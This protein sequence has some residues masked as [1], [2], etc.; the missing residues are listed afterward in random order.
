MLHLVALSRM[1][2]LA[3]HHGLLTEDHIE[4]V[5]GLHDEHTKKAAA[6]GAVAAAPASAATAEPAATAKVGGTAGR[7]HMRHGENRDSPVPAE[8]AESKPETGSP[9]KAE[10]GRR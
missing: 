8:G 4:E 3:L 7:K 5:H 2:H 1:E 10:E 9:E 6:D